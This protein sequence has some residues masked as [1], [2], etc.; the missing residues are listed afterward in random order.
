M[1][2]INTCFYVYVYPHRWL[3]TFTD[4]ILSVRL[5]DVPSLKRLIGFS[6]FNF[7]CFES[8]DTQLSNTC[9]D[10]TMWT[11]AGKLSANSDVLSCPRPLC[12]IV[13]VHEPRREGWASF[14]CKADAL[15][16]ANLCTAGGGVG[17]RRGGRHR[18]RWGSKNAV[19]SARHLETGIIPNNHLMYG[20]ATRVSESNRL[21]VTNASGCQV[22]LLNS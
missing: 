6:C 10:Y 8:F 5:W 19:I 17:K 16:S 13:L 7:Y 12:D 22:G 3:L 20:S 1:L 14:G 18:K 4:L 2:G 21:L 15:L 11:E 9:F